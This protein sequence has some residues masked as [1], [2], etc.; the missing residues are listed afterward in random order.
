MRHLTA[1]VLAALLILSLFA[2]ARN[3]RDETADAI[4]TVEPS[5]A[6]EPFE[7]TDGPAATETAGST[8]EPEIPV[9]SVPLMWRVSDA[10]GH[11]LY[12]FGTCHAGDERN[13][14]VFERV[15]PVV[16][17][18]DALAVEANTVAYVKN[19][20]QMANDM[21]QYILTDGS[22][23][24][25]HMP[26]ELYERTYDLLAQAKMHPDL[27]LKYNLAWWEQLVDEALM[28]IYSDLDFENA[29]EDKLI[30]FAY[31]K[32]MP[33]L[34]VESVPFQMGLLNSFDD[35][36]YLILIEDMMENRESYRDDLNEL[37]ELWLSGDR[38]AF[39]EF[40]S[41]ED[42]ED[43]DPDKY[44]EE[45]IALIEDYDRKLLDD[46]NLGMRDR[47]IEYL[48]SG[49]TVFFA[50]GAAHMA[51]DIGLV[52]LL[53]DAGYTVEEVDY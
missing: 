30:N 46:R 34:E 14:G 6:T 28:T 20:D 40:L 9:S 27:F 29:M 53:S 37:Y 42:E 1:F 49:D 16:A 17:S 2:C 41:S 26:E 19:V 10:E 15:A 43:E 7:D 50:V 3:T 11:A 47:A 24:S 44:T 35:E 39:W 8:E 38:D 33:V 18:C 13:A 48:A 25:D 5:A 51:N 52:H 45:Q 21:K 12:L 4:T 36:L 31:E 32:E 23:V 22:A